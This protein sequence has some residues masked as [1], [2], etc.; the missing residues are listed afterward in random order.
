MALNF[1][2]IHTS[3]LTTS[4]LLLDIFSHLTLEPLLREE[5]FANEGLSAEKWNRAR[6]N[7]MPL[8]DSALRES[9]RRW[10]LVAKA[11]SRKVMRPDGVTLPNGQRLPHGTTVCVSGWGLHHDAETYQRPFEFVPDRFMSKVSGTVEPGAAK[12]KQHVAA[13][14]NQQYVAWG[15][16]K[17]ACPGRF[18]AVDFI[19]LIVL[20]IILEYD[21]MP[22]E[23][24]PEN[25]WIEYNVMPPP[26]A[27]LTVRRRKGHDPNNG[28]A[29]TL[30]A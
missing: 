4:N 6:L 3:T 7:R 16:G 22:L 8:L 14:T 25:V 15:I 17:H 13:E 21:I 2:A 20:R 23:R 9:Q 5:A 29:H 24:R 18:F 30:N 1:A 19:K 26:T 12:S 27:T 11:L 10:G 28:R